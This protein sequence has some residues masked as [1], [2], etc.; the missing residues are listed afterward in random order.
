M[1]QSIVVTEPPRNYRREILREVAANRGVQPQE[2]LSR[3]KTRRV[4]KVRDEVIWRWRSE[5]GYSYPKIARH[6]GMRDHT[7]ALHAV[8]RH[9]AANRP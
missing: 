4:V 1:P 9:E 7:S 5:L 3:D 2:I 6:I 8:R